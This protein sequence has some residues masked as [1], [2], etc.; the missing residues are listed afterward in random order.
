MMMTKIVPGITF[1][2]FFSGASQA[3]DLF[4][5][6]EQV[7]RLYQENIATFAV[8]YAAA[9]R[10]Q[11]YQKVLRLSCMQLGLTVQYIDP[12]AY[13][14]DGKEAEIAALKQRATRLHEQLKEQGYCE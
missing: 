3:A 2:F 10:S 1:F 8:G 14:K 6:S 4:E 12:A 9:A 7:Q 5:K 13:K 11:D